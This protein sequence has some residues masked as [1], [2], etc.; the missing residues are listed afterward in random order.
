MCH[1]GR[2]Y[3]DT[4]RYSLHW[5]WN[6]LYLT[7]K[8][9]YFKEYHGTTMLVVCTCFD[10]VLKTFLPGVLSRSRAPWAG[11]VTSARTGCI[12]AGSI[13]MDCRQKSTSSRSLFVHCVLKYHVTVWRR[14]RSKHCASEMICQNYKELFANLWPVWTDSTERFIKDFDSLL[15]R[16]R[17]KIWD[18]LVHSVKFNFVKL[19]GSSKFLSQ[20]V[21]S[22]H[23]LVKNFLILTKLKS[24]YKMCLI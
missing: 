18:I 6:H 1:L 20:V 3:S 2:C 19:H 21:Q 13:S 24:L 14:N 4:L 12:F 22:G 8:P 10:A 5:H 16:N 15:I 9:I 23:S 7:V 11:V 17:Q